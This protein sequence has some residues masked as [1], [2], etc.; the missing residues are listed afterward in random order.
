M[1]SKF[2]PYTVPTN[3]GAKKIAGHAPHAFELVRRVGHQ[4]AAGRRDAGE[5]P[6]PA[7]DRRAERAHG[8]YREQA[9]AGAEQLGQELLRVADL[10]ARGT[11]FEP[12]ELRGD[13]LDVLLLAA[14]HGRDDRE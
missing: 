13:G 8:P 12:P 4:P 3:V 6:H 9:V 11:L 5:G 2:M 1:W 10:P 14:D 7:V